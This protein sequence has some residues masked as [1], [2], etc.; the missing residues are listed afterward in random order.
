MSQLMKA[1]ISDQ[2]GRL[3]L[4]VAFGLNTAMRHSEILAV[5][6]DQ[7]DFDSRRIFI[8]QAKAGE[9]EQPITPALAD[10]LLRQRKMEDDE[11][12]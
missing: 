6:Y 10:M 8:P 11:N 5:R 1:A 12:G 7:I 4:F 9:R 3:W 2:D